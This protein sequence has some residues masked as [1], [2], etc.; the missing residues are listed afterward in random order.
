MASNKCAQPN[1][2][3]DSIK[4]S[5]DFYGFIVSPYGQ[6]IQTTYNPLYLV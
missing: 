6:I 1:C 4:M 2:N 3:I 5:F